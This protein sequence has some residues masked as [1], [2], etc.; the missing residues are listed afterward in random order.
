MQLGW[1]LETNV[2]R[3]RMAP[4][5]IFGL[6]TITKC[7]LDEVEKALF[8]EVDRYCEFI[9]CLFRIPKCNFC[10]VKKAMFQE[11]EWFFVLFFVSLPSQS[12]TCLKSI[13]RFFKWSNG[14]LKAF[15]ASFQAQNATLR[16]RK[17]RFKCYHDLLKSFSFSWPAQI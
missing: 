10:Q 15:S 11:V 1:R 6:V 16:S 3:A 7:Y 13:K 8:Q 12:A 9:F 17:R 14:T 5:L 2:S 4:E